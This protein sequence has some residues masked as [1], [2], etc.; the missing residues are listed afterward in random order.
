MATMD[1]SVCAFKAAVMAI[2]D[3]QRAI[4]DG[5]CAIEDLRRELEKRRRPWLVHDI[6]ERMIARKRAAVQR[7]LGRKA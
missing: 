6:G 7:K 4:E 5:R 2:F 3:F 1:R